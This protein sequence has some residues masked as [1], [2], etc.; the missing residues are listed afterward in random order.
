MRP[1]TSAPEAGDVISKRVYKPKK[2][3]SPS[4]YLST[5]SGCI[6]GVLVFI[7][8]FVGVISLIEVLLGNGSR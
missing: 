5:T 2:A 8:L 6:V 7:V 1:S 4:E 3:N